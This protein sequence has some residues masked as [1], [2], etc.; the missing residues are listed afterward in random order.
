[1]QTKLSVKKRRPKG[2]LF[3]IQSLKK[4]GAGGLIVVVASSDNDTANNSNSSQHSDDY[5]ATATELAFFLGASAYALYLGSSNCLSSRR[6]GLSHY[7]GAYKR[8]GRNSSE[9]N[10]TE[11][12][13]CAPFLRSALHSR[14][15]FA[16][17]L[18]H[19]KH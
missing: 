6:K 10:L 11:T 9:G 14:N 13:Y 19:F 2:R 5:A 12:H 8:S 15:A 3:Q 7:G 18:F 4:S 16:Q 1:M 17:Q